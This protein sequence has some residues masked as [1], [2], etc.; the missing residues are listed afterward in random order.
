MKKTVY[1]FFVIAWA[2]LSGACRSSR[3]VQHMVDVDSGAMQQAE[4]IP[5]ESGLSQTESDEGE[6]KK[7]RKK[8]K[9]QEETTVVAKTTAQA[10]TAKLNLSL[11]AGSKKVNLGGNYRLKRD[12]VIQIN[13]TYT[14]LFTIN[15][16]T[17][18]LTP[19]YMLVVDRMG[20]RYCRVRYSD[21]PTLAQAGI[22]FDYLQR[23]FWGEETKSPTYD[24]TWSYADWTDLAGGQFPGQIQFSA[25]AKSTTYKATFY[26][27]NLRESADWETHTEI[28][29]RYAAVPF[30][31]I[32]NALMSV[33]K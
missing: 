8:K 15:V 19:D 5:S 10:V 22:N 33:A 4:P 31:G 17:M 20:K 25:R 32:L 24:L 26:L 6:S 14:M 2:L 3:H 1:I 13:L 16:G 30:D 27:S 28:S 18:E 23:V 29:D 7:K 11:D 21:V 12:E 9:R